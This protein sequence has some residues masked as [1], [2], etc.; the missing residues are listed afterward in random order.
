MPYRVF[1]VN[2]IQAGEEYARRTEAKLREDFTKKH[3]A[4]A[5]E[6]SEADTST[7]SKKDK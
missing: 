6:T 3:P 4:G 2:A 7:E 1:Y 5:P